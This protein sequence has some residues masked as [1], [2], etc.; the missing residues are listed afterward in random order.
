VF[1][2]EGGEKEMRASLFLKCLCVICLSLSFGV[3][4]VFGGT[5][6]VDGVDVSPAA[7][8]VGQPISLTS[9][10]WIGYA[11]ET[12]FAGSDYS[13]SG[14]DI[15]LNSYFID[16]NPGG[17]VIPIAE[18]WEDTQ[19]IGFLSAGTYDVTSYALMDGGFP[20]FP[21]EI[22]DVY[23]TSFVVTPEPASILLFASA[24]GLLRRTR[25]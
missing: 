15:V 10:G 12:S 5:V 16:T 17:I 6:T 13:I 4:D 18:R 11:F 14:N 20:G 1:G 7:P 8:H 19:I 9:Y 22:S 25:R 2:S 23:T 3:L 24:L 21:G